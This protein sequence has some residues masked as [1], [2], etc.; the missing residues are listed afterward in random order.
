MQHVHVE[1]PTG[2]KPI[3]IEV[4]GEPLGVV[5]PEAGGYRFLAVRFN[6]FAI[7]GRLFDS[8]DAARQAASEA[9]GGTP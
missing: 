1:K 3:T 4:G 8:V 5:V 2:N 9:L 6:A 7:E